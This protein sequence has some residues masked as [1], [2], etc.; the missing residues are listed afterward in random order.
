M[1]LG[2]STDYR[3]HVC[4]RLLYTPVTLLY[5]YKYTRGSGFIFDEILSDYT[6]YNDIKEKLIKYGLYFNIWGIY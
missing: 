1:L 2:L 5:I 3:L 6:R 4:V